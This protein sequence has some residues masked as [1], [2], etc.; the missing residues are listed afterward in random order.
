MS[1]L[2][3]R[4]MNWTTGQMELETTEGIPDE[5]RAEIRDEVA[6]GLQNNLAHYWASKVTLNWEAASM[7]LDMCEGRLT[8]PEIVETNGV[9]AAFN[10]SPI[11]PVEF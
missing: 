4:N 6:T 5:R 8:Q 10:F 11:Q 7:V 9:S 2:S 3:I 1:A